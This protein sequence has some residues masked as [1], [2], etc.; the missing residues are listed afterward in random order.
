[1][2]LLKNKRI[3]TLLL[4]ITMVLS[5]LPCQTFAVEENNT[6]SVTS[7][8]EKTISEDAATATEI[9]EAVPEDNPV[10]QDYQANINAILYTYLNINGLP[11]AEFLLNIPNMTE[12]EILSIVDRMGFEY[13]EAIYEIDV[14]EIKW[15][16]SINAGEITD[17]EVQNLVDNN[18]VFFVFEQALKN[19]YAIDNSVVFLGSSVTVLD[20]L[21]SI[22]SNQTNDTSGIIQ[23]TYISESNNIVTVQAK[24]DRS[25]PGTT[26][27]TITNSSGYTATLSFE[28]ALGDY[29]SISESSSSGTKQA[30]L[31]VGESITMSVTGGNRVYRPGSLTLSN[32]KLEKA[33]E[34]SNVTINF[35]STLGS[36]KAKDS[37]ITSGATITEISVTEGVALEATANPDS[38]A[39]FYGW[40]NEETRYLIS[41]EAS[42]T[43]KPDADM[44]VTAAFASA[45]TKAWFLVN[46]SY[47]YD[48]LH[49]AAAA[50]GSGGIV[51][52]VYDGTLS[53][54]HTVPAN[55]TLLIPFNDANTIITSNMNDY[56]DSNYSNPPARTLYRQLT[57]VN[58]SSITVNGSL[59]IGSLSSNQMIGQVGPYGAIVMEEGSSIS[60]ESGATLYAYGYIFHGPD[61]K[62]GTINVKG[63][64]YEPMSILDYAGNTDGTQ[65]VYNAGAF[66]Q[67]SF[68]IRNVEVPM[69][70]EYGATENVF[71]SLYGTLAGKHS[72]YISLFGTSSSSPFQLSSGTSLTK[73]FVSGRQ[74][75]EINGSCAINSISI[76][77]KTGLTDLS[78]V[79]LT[80]SETSGFPIPSNF[81][82]LLKNGTLTL[83]DSI[84]MT[85]GSKLTIDST[86]TIDT[87]NKNIYVFD[88]TVDPG[89]VTKTGAWSTLDLADVHGMYYCRVDKD[90]VLDVNGTMNISGGFYTSAG[91]ACITSSE[92]TGVINI[93]T[94]SS[95]TEVTIKTGLN[96]SG[97]YAVNPAQLLNANT[98]YI[99]TAQGIGT[100]TYINGFWHKG[101]SCSGGTASCK[102]KAECST[103]GLQYGDFGD[104]SFEQGICSV[105]GQYM[106]VE[107]TATNIAVN[108][109]LDMWFYVRANNVNAA[110]YK[111]VV[112]K[113]FADDRSPNPIVVT[114]PSG[115]WERYTEESTGIE[116]LRFCFSDI[117]AKEMTD[118]VEAAIFH[119]DGTQVSNNYSQTVQNYAITTLKNYKD[120]ISVEA[121]ALKHALV[122][123]L[124]YGASAQTQFAY[125]TA[126][127]ANVHADLSDFSGYL[128]T[129]TPNCTNQKNYGNN[130]AGVTVSATNTLMFTFYFKVADPDGMYAIIEY[131]PSGETVEKTVKVESKDFYERI[132]GSL[133]GVDVKELSIVDGRA[134]MTCT[135]YNSD[136]TVVTT[137][138][139]SI[140]GYAYRNAGKGKIFMDM[141]RF[142]DSAFTYFTAN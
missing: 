58:G 138:T 9:T 16:N 20:G 32:F 68:S 94:A 12:A 25:S 106:R 44:S 126:V 13:R 71:Y 57:M 2:F 118:S 67:R 49:S 46:G 6:T 121:E 115:Q 38:G 29:G 43:L 78:K 132:A 79:T 101:T 90:A 73:S 30:T 51:L 18:P 84:V 69:T 45:D 21:V 62:S 133:Y 102:Q 76:T 70:L 63:T 54:S 139:D 60:V 4:S 136:G 3:W 61:G 105:C 119:T 85:E 48:N 1:M 10:Y 14:E 52:P 89:A 15:E 103:C 41:K 65:T 83:G 140:E 11:E 39:I 24:G 28:Y 87:N 56:S 93:T 108:D 22:E 112:T 111:A 82:I 74:Y 124:E 47:L 116:Y 26:T 7:V 96:T 23:F 130:V 127:P 86:A 142:V 53:G 35:D 66:P 109:G 42:Y 92:G 129:A 123:M 141:M 34:T 77:I 137:A 128:T 5:L 104:H 131:T 134:L 55:V 33:A 81:D 114:I 36:V 64:V 91:N 107:I 99:D 100:Y 37:K 122:D 125:N 117:S 8:T 135:L 19:R 95:A 113:H 110:S 31:A 50:A 97:T 27:I 120:N 72:G 40:V 88:S 75:I 98:T 80:S 59:N 17:I